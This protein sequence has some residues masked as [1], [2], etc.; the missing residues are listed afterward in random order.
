MDDCISKFLCSFHLFQ[1]WHLVLKLLIVLWLHLH[2]KKCKAKWGYMCFSMVSW[3]NSSF[4]NP[5]V[6]T[7]RL[8]ARQ[9]RLYL[10]GSAD[11]TYQLDFHTPTIP[12]KPRN[13]MSHFIGLTLLDCFT[14]PNN[15][16]GESTERRIQ[17]LWKESWWHCVIWDC[18][19]VPLMY[20]AQKPLALWH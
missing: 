5:K 15:L 11:S 4:Q 20:I 2:E 10:P 12:Y 1:Q 19:E 6:F 3:H 13:S 8:L 14:V 7:W 9:R 18:S 17:I 16:K